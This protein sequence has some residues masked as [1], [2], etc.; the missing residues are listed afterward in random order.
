MNKKM[1]LLVLLC[2]VSFFAL[3]AQYNFVVQN[4]SASVYNT[5]Q[6]AYDN[7]SAGDTIYLPGGS[8]NFPSVDKPLVWIGVGYHPDSTAATYFTR[9]NNPVNFSGNCDN[10]YLTGMHFMSNVTF[11]TSGQDVTDVTIFRCRISGSLTLKYNNTVEVLLNDKVSECIIDGSIDAGMGSNVIIEKTILKG[12]LGH[13]RNSY[14][15]H[16]I[17]T[18]GARNSGSGYSFLLS[19]CENC[20]VKNSVINYYSYVNWRADVYG[21]INNNFLNNIFAGNITFPDGTNTGSYNITGVDLSTVF[22]NI[23]GNF[24]DFSY[25][26]NF[27]LKVGSPAAAAGMNGADIGIYGHTVPFKDGGLPVTPHI[28]SVE[29]NDETTNGLL[30]VSVTVGAQEN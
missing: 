17:F 30:P 26:H 9:I 19:Y 14:M 6:E 13:F 24:Q 10:T 20:Q 16:N 27:H 15:N 2:S 28:R 7:A 5:L 29:V 18:Y 25:L 3:Q 4:G 8:F 11:G 12:T 23:D 1:L 21:S 22:E